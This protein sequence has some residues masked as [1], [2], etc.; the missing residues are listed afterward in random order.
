MQLGDPSPHQAGLET[1]APK[2]Y[3]YYEPH[4]G[5]MLHPSRVWIEGYGAPLMPLA[6]S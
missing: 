4:A 2:K 3:H 5:R 1:R 6:T